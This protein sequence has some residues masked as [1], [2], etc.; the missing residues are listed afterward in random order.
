MTA[1]KSLS[2]WEPIGERC[3]IK[4]DKPPE[5]QGGI[6]LPE[7]TREHTRDAK[8]VAAG[9]DCKQV[10]SGDRVITSLKS[11]CLEEDHYVIFERDIFAI[12]R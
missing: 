7:T 11:L 5:S 10:K 6:F 1:Q 4:R 12:K 3:I 2:K 8:V 9:P